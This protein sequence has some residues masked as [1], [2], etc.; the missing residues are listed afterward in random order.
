MIHKLKQLTARTLAALIAVFATSGAWAAV[1]TPTVVWDGDLAEGNTK[2]GSDGN[3]YTFTLNDANNTIQNGVLTIGAQAA[4]G[5]RVSIGDS[6]ATSVSVLIRYT[7]GV[8]PSQSEVPVALFCDCGSSTASPDVGVVSSGLTSRELWP[9]FGIASDDGRYYYSGI[10]GGATKPQL[11]AGPGYLLFSYDL[12]KVNYATGSTGA[13]LSGG[14]KSSVNQGSTGKI[15]YVGVGGHTGL[16]HKANG[17]SGSNKY[18]PWQGLKI[19]GVAIFVGNAYTAADLADYVWP[20]GENY[21][22]Y[23]YGN[24][25]LTWQTPSDATGNGG[26]YIAYNGVAYNDFDIA[27]GRDSGTTLNNG[28][29]TSSS[30]YWNTFCFGQAG[31]TAPGYV[32]RLAGDYYKEVHG[33]FSPMTIGGLIV[34]SGATGYS[35][36]NDGT[37]RSAGLGDPTGETETWFDIG[38]NF[39]IARTGGVSFMG[40]VNLDIA[41]GKTLSLGSN[42]SVMKVAAVDTTKAPQL[43]YATELG[44]S[45]KL[46]GEGKLSINSGSGTLTATGSTMDYSDLAATSSSAEGAFVQGTLVV[47]VDTVFKFPAGATFPYFVAKS[48]SGVINPSA[49]MYIGGVAKEGGFLANANGSISYSAPVTPLSITTSGNQAWPAEWT[50]NAGNYVV[51]VG[52]N[53]Q[54]TFTLGA[55]TPNSIVFNLEDGAV[56]TLSGTLTASQ[57]NVNGTG[58]LKTGAIICNASGKIGGTVIGDGTIIYDSIRPTTTGNDVVLTNPCWEGTVVVRGYN[59]AKNATGTDRQLFPQYWGSSNS[60]IKWNGVAGYFTDNI[61]CPAAWV[62]EDLVENNTTYDALTKVEGSSSNNPISSPSLSGTGTFYDNSAPQ[63]IFKFARLNNF[64]GVINIDTSGGMNVQ[65]GATAI[66]REAGKITI[67]SGASVTIPNGSTWTARNG[68]S[69]KSTGTLTVD[70]TQSMKVASIVGTLDI[71]E[72]R[73]VTL[74]GDNDALNYDGSGTV[75]VHGTLN[76]AGIRWTVGAQNE[77]NLHEGGVISGTGPTNGNLDLHHNNGTKT[78]HAYGNATISATIAAR[79]D[80]YCEIIVDEGKTLTCSGQIFGDYASSIAKKGAGTLKIT[81]TSSKLPSREAGFIELATG[82]WNFGLSRDLYG[83]KFTAGG[84]AVIKVTQTE[85]EY[86]KGLLEICNIDSSI[87]HVTVVKADSTETALEVSAGAASL[88]DGTAV[89]GGKACTFDWEFNGDL[90]SGGKTANALSYDTDMNANNSFDGEG[91]LYIRTHPYYDSNNKGLWTWADA[92]TVAIK[93]EVPT[94]SK[95]MVI[96]FGNQGNGCVG[97]ATS[98]NDGKVILF[99]AGANGAAETISEMAVANRSGSQ[100]LYL[101]S[102]TA[103]GKMQVYCDDTLI[104]NKTV[105]GLG[106]LKG[107]LQVGSLHG[108]V[109]Y[110]GLNRPANDDPATIDFVQVYNYAISDA[111]R[112]AIISNYAWVNPNQYTRTVSGDENLSSA[113]AWTKP[114]DSSTVAIPVADADAIITTSSSSAALTVNNDFTAATLTVNSSGAEGA[115]LRIKA[116]TGTLSAAKVEVNAPVTVDIGAVD[117]ASCPVAVADGQT[118]TFDVTGIIDSNWANVTSINRVKLTGVT[119]LG[120]GA[121]IAVSPA[122]AYYWSLSTVE[123]D[124]DYYLTFTPGRV[125]Q[126]IYWKGDDNHTYWSAGS[127]N[128]AD[129]YTEGTFENV[130]KYFL[131]DTVVIP[132]ASRQRWFGP[133][134]DGANIKFDYAG[135]ISVKKTGSLGYAL[136]NATVTVTAGTTIKFENDRDNAPE[137]YGGSIS[138]AGTVQIDDGV[139]ATFSNGA[140]MSC[141]LTGKGEVAYATFPASA[142]T[143]NN[144]WAGEVHLPAN[145]SISGTNF[146]NWGKSGS[147][148]V[149]DGDIAGWIAQNT[150]VSAEMV[151]DG[152]SLTVNDFS[153]SSYSFGKISGSGNISFNH[154]EN[155]Y[156]PSSLTIGEIAPTYSGTVN[157]NTT[158]TLNITTI[159]LTGGSSVAGGTKLLTIGGTGSFSVGSV[160]V[161]GVTQSGL[162]LAYVAND[163]VYVAVAT[164]GGVGYKTLAD[165]I[166]DAEAGTGLANIVLLDGYVVPTGYYISNNTVCKYQAARIVLATSATTYYTSLQAALDAEDGVSYIEVL[167]D[168]GEATSTGSNFYIKANGHSFTITSSNAGRGNY[169][170]GSIDFG[171]GIYLYSA[172]THEATFVWKAGVSSG[173]WSNKDNWTSEDGTV[174]AAPNNSLHDVSFS[175]DA[176]VSL[177]SN[178]A[179]GTMEV[180]GAVTLNLSAAQDA[181]VA[182]SDIV[183]TSKSASLILVDRGINKVTLYCTPRTSLGGGA[184]VVSETVGNTTTYKVVYGSIFSVY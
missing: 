159:A 79:R 128:T 113:A 181:V 7:D 148:I 33:K 35:F 95:G 12:C 106:S 104:D 64:T 116:G 66:A 30:V 105:D 77:I 108:G 91:H 59:K 58:P 136:K 63:A 41:Q 114:S 13:S 130:T 150:S 138:G 146:G 98:E 107:T 9:C 2:Q 73:T 112:A 29:T 134:S 145:A 140:Y 171:G 166:V 46:H 88:G 99:K 157:N 40:D 103:D 53:V 38:E 86:G 129:F 123:D 89:V 93:C 118:L 74:T 23:Q 8:A 48:I 147:K 170:P 177:A 50:D 97:L 47:D 139:R 133:V 131:G 72:G 122:T 31:Y 87:E 158:A 25:V 165:A 37:N 19:D 4:F 149:L 141:K 132:N 3:S 96:T 178:V 154:K 67:L 51:N 45:L 14:S 57:I 18:P 167:S 1:P 26:D 16:S 160:T 119:T 92:W 44:G 161:G 183:L 109:D 36:P 156:Q 163:G 173:E 94:T 69:I 172:A 32:L 169:T 144:S 117:F 61:N 56:V 6:N 143:F 151:L 110:I 17:S 54:T 100:H 164:Y 65:F 82:T 62:L 80:K 55:T 153:P 180:G 68:F 124:G 39:T 127:D 34:E 42:A 102:K 49:T 120:V 84:D 85:E 152:H 52:E 184:K 137:I 175:T 21:A 11:P 75:N 121:S 60:K 135:S 125:S 115:A 15:T 70:N 78:I 20:S 179:V 182:A 28:N 101:F 24:K 111:Q 43:P 76:M 162:Q 90:N 176:T 81:N 83:Y 155:G 71:A 126:E 174:V 27:S 5:A 142:P 168:G 10:D 22:K